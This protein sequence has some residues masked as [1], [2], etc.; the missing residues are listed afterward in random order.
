VL[1]DWFDPF[2]VVVEICAVV[3]AACWLLSVITREYS[4]VDRIWSII[5][6]VYAW[7]VAAQ[8]GFAAPRVVLMAVLVTLWAARLTFNFARK[9]GYKKGGEDYRWAILR[10]R[11]GPVGFQVFNATFIAPFQ[12]VLLLLIVA[13]IITAAKFTQTPFG[14]L[15]VALAVL[16]IVFLVGETVADEQQWRFQLA[17]AARKARG[18]SGPEF[19]TTGLFRFSRHPNF[20]C[21][22]SQWWVIYAFAVV[23]SG[24]WVQWSGLGAVVLTALFQGSTNMTEGISKSRYPAYAEYQ[25]STSRL[26]PWF[27]AKS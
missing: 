3:S 9:G 10:E 15:D 24:E 11:I 27:P 18:E 16:F 6:A 2:F 13:P 23:A 26:I 8:S 22:V 14:A 4:W 1:H 21:E 19:C 5:P 12:N 17:K 25:R 7:V 20:F